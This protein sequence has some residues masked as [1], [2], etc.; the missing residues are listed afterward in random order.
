MLFFRRSIVNHIDA[1]GEGSRVTKGWCEKT[2]VFPHHPSRRGGLADIDL[3]H[4]PGVWVCRARESCSGD[5]VPP[6]CTVGEYPPAPA[7]GHPREHLGVPPVRV[8]TVPAHPGRLAAELLQPLQCIF[9]LHVE[10]LGL[11]PPPMER[12]GL[13]LQPFDVGEELEGLDLQ[14]FSLGEERRDPGAHA[15]DLGPRRLRCRGSRI[16]QLDDVRAPLAP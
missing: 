12:E 2:V 7:K 1:V 10:H 3:H 13:D 6:W 8:L 9:D 4:A 11:H 16:G 15:V 5:V 14:P